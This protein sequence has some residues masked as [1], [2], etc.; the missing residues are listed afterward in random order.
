MNSKSTRITQSRN[1]YVF[2]NRIEYL[3]QDKVQTPFDIVSQTTHII[4]E[5]QLLINL[6]EIKSLLRHSEVYHIPAP[7]FSGIAAPWIQRFKKVEHNK[8][9]DLTEEKQSAP[10]SMK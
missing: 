7:N 3:G 8:V 6:A 9:G 1:F 4:R 2:E 10:I 5:V